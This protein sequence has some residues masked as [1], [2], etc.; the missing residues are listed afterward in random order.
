M[1]AREGAWEKALWGTLW[2]TLWEKE[3]QEGRRRRKTMR[4]WF[5]YKQNAG[6]IPLVCSPP[7]P[8]AVPASGYE[9][10]ENF[11]IGFSDLQLV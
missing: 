1:P 8:L 11:R 7:P 10:A 3:E 9:I 6:T 4:M 5:V 2:G